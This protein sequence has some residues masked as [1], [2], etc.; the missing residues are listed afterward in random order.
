MDAPKKRGRKPKVAPASAPAGEGIYGDFTAEPIKL[1]RKPKV[2]P[3]VVKE[4]IKIR[5]KPKVAPEAV[6]EEVKE[7]KIRRKPKVA[8]EVVKEEVKE[9]KIR[10]KPKVAPVKEEVKE[11][12]IKRKRP[13]VA[14]EPAVEKRKPGRP[15]TRPLPDP[16]APKR[17][18]GRPRKVA[19]APE[20]KRKRRIPDVS[21]GEQYTVNALSGA[22]RRKATR[23]DIDMIGANVQKA[24]S[25]VHLEVEKSNAKNEPET[26]D[27]NRLLA[28][29]YTGQGETGYSLVDLAK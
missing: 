14:P 28:E 9:I 1:R 24:I 3:E 26:I 19:P 23:R 12:K 20:T 25:N 29:I 6:K 21:L 10:R 8:P 11:I 27:M 15:R 13:Q 17:K 22:K 18:P 2:A 4:E 5:R 7:I 16:N